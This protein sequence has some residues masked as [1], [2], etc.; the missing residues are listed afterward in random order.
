MI[1]D[2]VIGEGEMFL[3]PGEIPHSPQ[4]FPDTIGLVIE[5]ERDT[6]EAKDRLRWY[7]D[8]C[9]AQIYE[10]SF[11][12]VDL[13]Q[14]LVPVIERYYADEKKRTC[15]VCGHVSAVPSVPG[16][17]GPRAKVVVDS[18]GRHVQSE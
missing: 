4:R 5:R 12:C 7:C 1:T 3:L 9:A 18:Q 8:Q 16:K 13:G 10:E 17:G 14:Q 6:A 11:H 15:G 2:I